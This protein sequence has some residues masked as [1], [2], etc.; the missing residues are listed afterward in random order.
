MTLDTTLHIVRSTNTQK[1]WKH[2]RPN[3]NQTEKCGGGQKEGGL[4]SS[5]FTSLI[6]PLPS[7]NLESKKFPIT[8]MPVPIQALPSFQA[9][10]CSYPL[11]PAPCPVYKGSIAIPSQLTSEK[12][13][14][15]T[16]I[17]IIQSK[18]QIIK[19]KTWSINEMSIYILTWVTLMSSTKLFLH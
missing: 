17:H 16:N 10:C 11:T 8:L 12:L 14:W 7:L 18:Q 5:H 15:W 9:P 19:T 4:N 13:G 6:L 1:K 3:F 2:W